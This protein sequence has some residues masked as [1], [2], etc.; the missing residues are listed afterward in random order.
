[1]SLGLPEE[2]GEVLSVLKRRIRDDNFDQD[3]MKK[4]LGDVIHY[5]SM[6][7]NYFGY[8]PSDII[9]I[10]IAKINDRRSRGALRGSGDDR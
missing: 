2:V 9:D 10:N 6:M 1:M 3:K 4:E 5:W 7:C 8:K